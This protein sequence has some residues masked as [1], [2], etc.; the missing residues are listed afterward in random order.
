MKTTAE[1]WR[2]G[3]GCLMDGRDSLWLVSDEKS[4]LDI[5]K[6]NKISNDFGKI[7]PYQKQ[8]NQ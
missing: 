8:L 5:E 6:K 3:V 4:D 2:G 7:G 1:R